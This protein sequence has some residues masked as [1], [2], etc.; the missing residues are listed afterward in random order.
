VRLPK[1]DYLEP[2]DLQEALELLHAHGKKCR[3][4]AGGTD[5]LVRM[6]QRLATPEYVLSLKRLA[7]LDYLLEENGQVRIGARTSLH[8]VGASTTVQ[9]RLPSLFQAVHA[10]GSPSIQHHRGTVGGNVCQDSRCLF[11]N[12]SAFW[13]SGR[14]PCHKAGGRICY[15]HEGSDRCRSTNQ[16]DGATALMALDAQA[17]LSSNG[18][19]RIIPFQDLFTGKGETPISLEPDELLTEIRIALP[20]PGEGSAYQRVAYRSAV[21][22][23]IAAAAVLVRTQEARIQRARVVI[24]AMTNAPLLLARA[25]ELLEGRAIS[26]EEALEEVAH[27][28]RDHA[29]PFAV[30]NV[31]STAEYR[32][33]MV[34]VLVRRALRDAMAQAAAPQ[35]KHP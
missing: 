27:L 19:A 23:P 17:V 1:F 26:D 31:G 35:E 2:K 13:R 11:Y 34:P 6:K 5:L 21:D 20:L 33:E 25:S 16:S 30:N 3:V 8:A 7:E 24:G 14:Q 12:Q 15:A 18:S 28:A 22:Y 10:I 9:R 29:S 32:V 4:L